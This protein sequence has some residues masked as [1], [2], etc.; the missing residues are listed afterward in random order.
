MVR[1]TARRRQL[2]AYC[3]LVEEKMGGRVRSGILQYAD[4]KLAMQF[5]DQERS[6][7]MSLLEQVERARGEADVAR[8]H[9]QA[10]KC[11]RCGVKA[12]CGQA[13]A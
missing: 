11:E 6:W 8:N 12:C 4:R 2:F 9:E 7:I 13:L 1:M 3:L 10:R 5:G